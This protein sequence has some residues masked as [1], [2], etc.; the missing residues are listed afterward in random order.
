MKNLKFISIFILLCGFTFALVQCT[1]DSFNVKTENDASL[2]M[3]SFSDDCLPPQEP[4]CL[5]D[6]DTINLS[7]SQFSGCVFKVHVTVQKCPAGNNVWTYNIGDF[8]VLSH[9][10]AA[11]D[12]IIQNSSQVDLEYFTYQFGKWIRNALTNYY[13]INDIQLNGVHVQQ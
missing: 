11:F 12:S 1:K 4:T 7:V 5:Q 9:N 6:V 8:E 3:R 10:C 13:L 2:E